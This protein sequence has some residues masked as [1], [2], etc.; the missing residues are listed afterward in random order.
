VQL[1]EGAQDTRRPV[2][3]EALLH[4]GA[5]ERVDRLIAHLASSRLMSTS[6]Q[7]L[8]SP[9]ENFVEVSH[10]ALIREWPALREW[11]KENREDLRLER[12][13]L[14]AAE[15]WHGLERDPSALLHGIR[16]ARA[17][18][19]LARQQHAPPL[20]GDFLG[21]SRDARE[22]VARK[23][24]EA[25]DR[26][27]G[28]S[29]A[30]AAQAEEMLTRD[31][32]AAL[33]LAIRGWQTAKTP[34][35]HLAVARAFPQLLAQPEGHAHRV[36]HAAFSPDGQCIVTVS[37]DATALVWN[38]AN[39]QLLAKLEGHT[40]LVWHA[41]FSPDGQRIVTASEDKTA[42]RVERG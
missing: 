3:K 27:Q 13:L 18:E 26:D 14:Q 38:A 20:L 31:Q 25:R 21:A 24:R 29:R 23:E 39:G 34:E 33:A 28:E 4:L 19:W 8:Q 11:L 17:Q 15:E 36:R 5:P 10:E 2:P 6:G 1:G 7:G 32:P 12:R 40:E 42:S 35:A 16:L 41:A 22:E 9:K 30:L 37:H